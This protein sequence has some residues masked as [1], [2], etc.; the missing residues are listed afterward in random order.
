MF[1][2]CDQPFPIEIIHSSKFKSLWKKWGGQ[3]Q[4]ACLIQV[5]INHV[6]P[7]H[8]SLLTFLEISYGLNVE[9]GN[10]E[11]RKCAQ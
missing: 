1:A 8:V 7:F 3:A 5:Q 4:N 6:D 9:T 10:E 2:V 11:M